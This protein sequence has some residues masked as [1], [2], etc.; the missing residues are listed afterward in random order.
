M[1]T[2][3]HNSLPERL[4]A[5]ECGKYLKLWS[6]KELSDSWKDVFAHYELPGIPPQRNLPIAKAWKEQD[7]KNKFR[8]RLPMALFGGGATLIAPILIK[9]LHQTR[10]TTL[11]T[12]SILVFAVG[13]VLS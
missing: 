9:T 11:L 5:F 1:K 8:S 10:L 6:E 2:T 3:E 13:A 4:S 7:T 12:T